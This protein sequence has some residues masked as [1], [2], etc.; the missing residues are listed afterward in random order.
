MLPLL[1]AGRSFLKARPQRRTES[2]LAPGQMPP[3]VRFGLLRR[4]NRSG[5]NRGDIRIR[6][7]DL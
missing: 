3:A 2:L 7:V 4:E 1:R 6:G 5:A